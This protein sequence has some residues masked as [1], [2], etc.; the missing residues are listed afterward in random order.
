MWLKYDVVSG[1][2]GMVKD[3]NI[4]SLVKFELKLVFLL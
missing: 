3:L 2:R 1:R 4:R